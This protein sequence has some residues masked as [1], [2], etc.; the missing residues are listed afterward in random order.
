MEFLSGKRDEFFFLHPNWCLK[1]SGGRI[2]ARKV[3]I[4]RPK[5]APG[6]VALNQEPK[7]AAKR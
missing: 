2:R 3:G 5:K 7:M 6:T 1:G 4:V